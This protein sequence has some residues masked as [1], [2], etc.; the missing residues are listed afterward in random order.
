MS[1]QLFTTVS[2]EQQETIIG[3]GGNI[4]NANAV[5]IGN[6]NLVAISNNITNI[7][8]IYMIFNFFVYPRSQSRKHR[9]CKL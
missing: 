6:N 2:I 7:K 4:N 3:G 8:I 1:N 5:A 9:R